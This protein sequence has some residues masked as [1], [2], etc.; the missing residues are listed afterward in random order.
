MA[1]RGVEIALICSTNGDV[2]SVD[3]EWLEHYDTIA[4][5]RLSELRCAAEALGIKSVITYGYRD[6]GMVARRITITRTVLNRRM[7]MW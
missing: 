4:E 7:K 2:G 1:E 3:P 6:S 5:L